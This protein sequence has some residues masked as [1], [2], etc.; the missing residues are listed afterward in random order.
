LP[1]PQEWASPAA[2]AE[3][4]A[5]LLD[6]EPMRALVLVMQAKENCS[7]LCKR[8]M[9]V[10]RAAA[11]ASAGALCARLRAPV[12]ADA[13]APARSIWPGTGSTAATSGACFWRCKGDA[14]AARALTRPGPL[15]SHRQHRNAK[16]QEHTRAPTSPPGA[17]AAAAPA[18]APAEA[19]DASD[20]LPTRLSARLRLQARPPAEDPRDNSA[21]DAFIEQTLRPLGVSLARL[22]RGPAA[23]AAAT[24][25]GPAFLR[26]TALV[27][28]ETL[29]QDYMHLGERLDLIREALS[30]E[31]DELLADGGAACGDAGGA[32]WQVAVAE[33]PLDDVLRGLLAQQSAAL[34]H[35]EER[36]AQADAAAAAAAA[37]SD[38]AAAALAAGEQ[39]WLREWH[40]ALLALL[41]LLTRVQGV[42]LELRT[43]PLLVC[44]AG[45]LRLC[46]LLDD[47]MLDTASALST[48]GAW[49]RSLLE[50]APQQAAAAVGAAQQP[51]PPLLGPRLDMLAAL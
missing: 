37:A 44:A 24:A 16:L 12:R 5:Q 15:R 40:A 9:L 42:A 20:T 4:C 13:R 50:R 17:A 47:A 10:R 28:V 8:H 48:R 21:L 30:S 41:E 29:A 25:H 33:H 14:C 11:A 23:Q 43:D 51:R 26:G 34:R 45:M 6:A 39:A 7:V 3:V 22:F 32:A 38:A 1:T 2:R 31:L 35:C 46:T 27:A 19:P 18:A 49:V 36:L